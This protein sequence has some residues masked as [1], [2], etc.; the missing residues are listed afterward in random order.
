MHYGPYQ[1][2]KGAGIAQSVWR[3]DY[4]SSIPGKGELFLSKASRPVFGPPSPLSKGYRRGFPPG[5]KSCGVTLTTQLHLPRS[6][7][8]ELYLYS[9][10]IFMPWCLVVELRAGITLLFLFLVQTE[11][12][13]VRFD[14]SKPALFSFFPCKSAHNKI[15]CQN[16]S[17]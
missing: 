2:F 6:R 10:Y 7:A 15:H 5:S 9:Q 3:L 14:R 13:M 11:K 17:C 12:G 1:Q 16:S 8:V 4:W